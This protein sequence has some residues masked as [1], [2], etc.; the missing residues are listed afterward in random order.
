MR[1]LALASSCILFGACGGADPRLEPLASA[2]IVATPDRTAFGD[3]ELGVTTLGECVDRFGAGRVALV[4]S[5]QVGLE[6]AYEGGELTLL[7]LYDFVLRDDDENTALRTAPRDL[8]KFLER[9][10]QR[11]GLPLAGV[12]VSSSGVGSAFYRGA[13]AP[14]TTLGK[15]AKLGAPWME[16]IVAVGREPDEVRPP[17]LAG[18]TPD[19]PDALACFPDRGLALYGEDGVADPLEIELTRIALFVPERP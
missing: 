6:C 3:L 12:T 7:F 17:M 18:M 15:P 11:R 16:A 2:T 8:A 19:W 1:T 5:D 10:P 14:S 4:A 9:F 13:L